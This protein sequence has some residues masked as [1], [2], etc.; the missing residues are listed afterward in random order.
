MSTL[1]STRMIPVALGPDRADRRGDRR[2][3][4]RVGAGE[5]LVQQQHGRLLRERPG[6]L[7]EPLLAEREVAAAAL[8]VAQFESVRDAVQYTVEPRPAGTERARDQPAEQPADPG[9]PGRRRTEQDVLPDGQIEREVRMLERARE[10]RAG[11]PRRGPTEFAAPDGQASPIGGLRPVQQVDERGLPCAVRPDQAEDLPLREA[12]R[13]VVDRVD[14]A[15]ALSEPGALQQ[16][17]HP[18]VPFMRVPF[19]RAPFMRV[20]RPRSRLAARPA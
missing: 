9:E 16:N 4:A 6:D 2:D 15:V 7:D 10:P 18:R 17:G 20:S 5:R 11:A 12:Q 3:S 19:M 1:W 13:H 8:Q 14:A